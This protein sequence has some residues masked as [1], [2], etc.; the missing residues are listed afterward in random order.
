[1]ASGILSIFV[2]RS[3]THGIPR[4]CVKTAQCSAPSIINFSERA[5]QQRALC[6]LIGASDAACARHAVLGSPV[7][8]ISLRLSLHLHTPL[9]VMEGACAPMPLSTDLSPG[10]APSSAQMK[11]GGVPPSPPGNGQ[12]QKKTMLGAGQA[13]GIGQPKGAGTPAAAGLRTA[14]C[15]VAK[16]SVQHYRGRTARL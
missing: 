14:V 11:R 7:C 9:Q 2:R 3:M 1:M 4:H 13:L 16:V 6:V 12:N 8:G 5:P 10:I 15:G